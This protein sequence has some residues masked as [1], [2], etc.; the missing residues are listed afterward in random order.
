M[1]IWYLRECEDPDLRHVYTMDWRRE[2]LSLTGAAPNAMAIAK[3][4]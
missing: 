2:T 3:A 1:R 4:T